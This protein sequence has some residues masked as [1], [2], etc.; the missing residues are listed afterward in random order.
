MRRAW[1]SAQRLGAELDLLCVVA[2]GRPD[3]AERAEQLEAL[4]RLASVLGAHLLVEEGD[5]VA[6]RPRAVAAERGTTYVLMR[7]QP[8]AARPPVCGGFTESPAP[9]PTR[10]CAGVRGPSI[11]AADWIVGR[12]RRVLA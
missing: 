11:E 12:S 7:R 6:A 10:S 5:D 4:R 8:R 9:R 3:R 1:R 2:P